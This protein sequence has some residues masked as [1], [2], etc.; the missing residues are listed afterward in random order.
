MIVNAAYM[1]VRQASNNMTVYEKS[2]RGYLNLINYDNSS[3]AH[4]S[5][6]S[7]QRPTL[8]LICL[9]SIHLATW[10]PSA[11][12][13]FGNAHASLESC[14]RIHDTCLHNPCQWPCTAQHFSNLT[15]FQD[16]CLQLS[17]VQSPFS[18]SAFSQPNL[19]RLWYPERREYPRSCY[20]IRC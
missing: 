2:N 11:R 20:C 17:L 10:C 7:L 4:R 13:W 14:H 5:A 6:Y 16:L 3:I 8:P 19:L 1:S 15:L 18:G 12:I 9:P